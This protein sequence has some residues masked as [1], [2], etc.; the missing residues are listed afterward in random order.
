[1]DSVKVVPVVYMLKMKLAQR[2]ITAKIAGDKWKR[3][4]A[5][6]IRILERTKLRERQDHFTAQQVEQNERVG[7]LRKED[8]IEPENVDEYMNGAVDE[9]E[10]TDSPATQSDARLKSPE[11]NKATKISTSRHEE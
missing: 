7:D 4:S 11:R 5:K 3:T 8:V 1:M 6:T 2:E 9:D 10:L